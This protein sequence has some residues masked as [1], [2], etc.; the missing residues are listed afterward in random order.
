MKRGREERRNDEN[1]FHAREEGAREGGGNGNSIG[2]IPKRIAEREGCFSMKNTKQRSGS[3]LDKQRER[4]RERNLYVHSGILYP[5]T[6]S[7]GYIWRCVNLLPSGGEGGSTNVVNRYWY[8]RVIFARRRRFP[9]LYQALL[10]TEYEDYFITGRRS[11][12]Y[13]PS[14][15]EGC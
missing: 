5:Y 7:N 9:R 6:R 2:D 10:V 3:V 13:V 8:W 12:F 4:E 15:R 11:P 14:V 1:K